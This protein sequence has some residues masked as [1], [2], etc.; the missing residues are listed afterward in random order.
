MKK[1]EFETLVY[2]TAAL[3]EQLEKMGNAF[4]AAAT[5]MRALLD[6]LDTMADE[7]EPHADA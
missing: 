3:A 5:E 6:A 2:R 1:S 4:A 7:D